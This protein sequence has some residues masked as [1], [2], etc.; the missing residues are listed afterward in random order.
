MAEPAGIDN[1]PTLG[2]LGLGRM[3]TP[4][5]QRLLAAGYAL[6]AY[7]PVQSSM[8][9]AVARGAAAGASP[10]DVADRADIVFTSL[11]T[12]DVTN[13]SQTA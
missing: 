10:R 9:D 4:M 3:G 11:P 13:V 1:K 5:S 2:F 8:T 6:V 7:D 12:P